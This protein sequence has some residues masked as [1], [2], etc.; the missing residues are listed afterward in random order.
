MQNAQS[1]LCCSNPNCQVVNPPS[2]KFCQ[3]CGTLLPKRYLWPI[4]KSIE[5]YKSGDTIANRYLVTKERLLL[6]LNPILSPHI[7]A[8]LPSAITTYLKLFPYRLHVPQVYGILPREQGKKSSDIWL[9]EQ[10]PVDPNTG[11][12]TP[13]LASVWK[14]TSTMRQLNWL[15][16]IAQLWEPLAAQ[17]V[18]SSLLVPRIIRVEGPIV[19]LLELVS[20]QKT[21]QLSQLGELW[22]QW[23]KNSPSTLPSY[24]EQICQKLIHNEIHSSEQLLELLEPGLNAVGQLSSR[25]I[26]IATQTDQGPSRRRN[27]DACYPESGTII[28]KS[29]GSD[30]L[31]IVCDGIGGHEGGNVAS[32]LAIKT[33]Q[34]QVEN[35]ELT[36]IAPDNLISELEESVRQANDLI[37][38]RNDAEQRQA[39]QRMGTTLVMALAHHHE[40]Y[41]THIGD[42][43]AYWITRTGCYQITLD[44]DVASRE[45]RLGYAIY[46]EA[47]QQATAGSLVQALG[48][49]SSSMLHPTVSRFVIDDDCVF[50]LCSDGLSDNDRVE[51]NWETEILPVLNGSVTVATAAA[52]LVEIAN[53]QNGHDNVTVALVHCQLTPAGNDQINLEALFTQLG[54]VF[55][56]SANSAIAHHESVHD[57]RSSSRLK[58]QLIQDDR[59]QLGLTGLLIRMVILL[60]LGGLLVYLLTPS[61]GEKIKT[62]LRMNPILNPSSVENGS[63][64]PTVTPRSSLEVNNVFKIKSSIPTAQ[65]QLLLNLEKSSPSIIVADGTILKLEQKQGKSETWLKLKVCKIP[66]PSNPNSPETASSRSLRA[67]DSGWIEQTKFIPFISADSVSES[68]CG[69]GIDPVKSVSPQSSPETPHND[70]N[71]QNSDKRDFKKNS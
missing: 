50:L 52:K 43:R 17:N 39:R 51:Q 63:T 18:A 31:A 15:W 3:K 24:L 64:N 7:V 47:L 11:K 14:G 62:L 65:L 26:N 37:A 1:I 16:Q 8:D 58:T 45:V 70:L 61:L 30:A 33:V 19:R 46:R 25:Q 67:G 4:G 27:E 40:V 66:N 21:P 44:D 23:I 5:S 49:N 41:I 36:D 56:P 20:D 69:V 34:Q 6:D 68:E 9:L 53:Q 59:P 48:M 28:A 2:S 57:H 10:I 55:S 71:K 22:W 13:E 29:P 35:L 60:G 12:L 32:N 54:L 42:T 38:Q